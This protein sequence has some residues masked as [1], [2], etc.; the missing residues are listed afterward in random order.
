MLWL[1]PFLLI[2]QRCLL[3]ILNLWSSAL[4]HNA[5]VE[6]E[7]V[8]VLCFFLCE[9]FRGNRIL[10]RKERGG[11]HARKRGVFLLDEHAQ[12]SERCRVGF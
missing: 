8:C 3:F 7:G 2:T 9:R 5:S 10:E 12:R 4:N 1:F 6:R 11:A